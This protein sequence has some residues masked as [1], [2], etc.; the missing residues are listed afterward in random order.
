MTEKVK[1]KCDKCSREF[2]N[3]SNAYSCSHN[4]TYC[5]KCAKEMI[6]I[7]PNCSGKLSK[8]TKKQK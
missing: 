3:D 2:K 6:Y 1:T 4:C 7:C 5:P 8:R